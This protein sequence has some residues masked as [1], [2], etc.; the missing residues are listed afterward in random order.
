MFYPLPVYKDFSIKG[1]VQIVADP[2]RNV[3][4]KL[5]VGICGKD[6]IC[7]ETNHI[8][9]G[10]FNSDLSNWTAVNTIWQSGQ[11][12]YNWN[13]GQLCRSFDASQTVSNL[14]PADYKLTLRYR[15][16]STFS[17]EVNL[18]KLPGYTLISQ[19]IISSTGDGSWKTVELSFNIAT[20]T[21]VQLSL[22]GHSLGTGGDPACQA[23][24]LAEDGFFID[25]VELKKDDCRCG[26]LLLDE[27]VELVPVC[28]QYKWQTLFDESE[29]IAESDPYNI[30]NL[31]PIGDNIIQN[32]NF[33]T[34]PYSIVTSTNFSFDVLSNPGNGIHFKIFINDKIYVIQRTTD[35]TWAPFNEII[36]GNLSDVRIYST[37]VSNYNTG[38]LSALQAIIDA[39][40]GTTTTLSGTTFTIANVPANMRVDDSIFNILSNEATLSTP[41][42]V[43]N[44][45]VYNATT[46]Q[47]NFIKYDP[48]QF[49]SEAKASVSLGIGKYYKIQFGYATIH[50]FSYRIEIRNSSNAVV[51]DTGIISLPTTFT[52]GNITQYFLCPLD[53]TYTVDFI[54]IATNP[55]SDQLAFDN[56]SM[57]EIPRIHVTSS[58]TSPGYTP[59]PEGYYTKESLY[60]VIEDIL[61]MPFDCAYS[62]CCAQPKIEFT[63][64]FPDDDTEYV[65]SLQQF[66]DIAQIVFPDIEMDGIIEDGECFKYCILDENKKVIACS[67]IFKR[68]YED[69]FTTLV[70][71]WN[72]ENAFGFKY[73]SD[74]ATNLIRLPFFAYG[75]DYPTAEKIYRETGGNYR[76]LST[77]IEKEYDVEVDK[78]PEWLHDMIIVAL[79]HDNVLFTTDRIGLVS[80]PIS[81]QGAY[82]PDW[83]RTI[84][85]KAKAKFKFRKKFNGSNSNCKSS[86]TCS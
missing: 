5:Y 44:N 74:T 6:T 59:I 60:A 12:A 50:N 70:E 24:G 17:F 28:S 20:A 51:F 15:D 47:L 30:C 84:D 85:F 78:L 41:T 37:N 80:Q 13:N 48:I 62:S 32:G 71:Y 16:L 76:R 77:V 33:D 64:T 73:P 46:K 8:T 26:E 7:D 61:G 36:T 9:N 79:K 27:D 69:C 39:R 52:G 83:K 75:A 56:I 72:N 29:V 3:S 22:I 68:T 65:Y 21:D 67:N 43:G 54:F 42:W 57:F 14:Q 82:T 34:N 19:Q 81:Q 58:N 35:I 45:M 63:H 1:Q 53:D 55:Y 18:F 31:N 66:W 4:N 23:T 40:H 49:A 2:P 38:L 25:D 11:M 10:A 86:N